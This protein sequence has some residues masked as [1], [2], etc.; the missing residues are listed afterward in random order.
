MGSSPW[1]PGSDEP[2]CLGQCR[3]GR[4]KAWGAGE[5]LNHDV[6]A[7]IREDPVVSPEQLTRKRVNAT[8]E[9]E[10]G[11]SHRGLIRGL[12]RKAA[13]VWGMFQSGDSG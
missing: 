7:Q 12:W 4:G 10:S 3:V 6:E 1:Y 13:P 8:G 5:V 11:R 2:S 9:C